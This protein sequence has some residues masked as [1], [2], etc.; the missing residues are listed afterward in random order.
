MV[1]LFSNNRL[2]FL[3]IVSQKFWGQSM[4]DIWVYEM[5]MTT[6]VI[7]P[8]NGI[9]FQQRIAAPGLVGMEVMVYNDGAFE[10]SEV[11]LIVATNV[12]LNYGPDTATVSTFV[13]DTVTN[14][15]K[16]AL[17]PD[18]IQ[19]VGDH[20][21]KMVSAKIARHTVVFLAET[22]KLSIYRLA[23][24]FMS[25]FTLSHVNTRYVP[26]QGLRLLDS[27]VAKNILD[28]TVYS[29]WGKKGEQ[30]MVFMLMEG[31]KSMLYELKVSG[32]VPTVKLSFEH[33]QT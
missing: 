13:F 1:I 2:V 24:I 31:P 15:Y 16:V 10:E 11:L 22:D 14:I 23:F 4:N 17:L 28:F 29:Q 5:S 7:S 20:L 27:L 26:F 30:A 32:T 25:D 9:S 6:G 33:Y 8:S 21:V 19:V 18:T 3:R 12:K